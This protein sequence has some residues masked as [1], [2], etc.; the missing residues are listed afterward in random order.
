MQGRARHGDAHGAEVR[1]EPPRDR[2]MEAG[3]AVEGRA[4]LIELGATDRRGN[5]SKGQPIEGRR[6]PAGPRAA[7]SPPRATAHPPRANIS[8][9]GSFSVAA[10]RSSE[11]RSARTLHTDE[12]SDDSSSSD[13]PSRIGPLR[14]VPDTANRHVYSE[15]SADSRARVQSPQKGRV[16][17]AMTPTSP[18]PSR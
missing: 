17:E 14:S 5:R 11:Y 8:T 1:S 9:L 4:R 18:E 6:D 16:T 15:P 2:A 13:A 12:I 7:A 10:L 3:P